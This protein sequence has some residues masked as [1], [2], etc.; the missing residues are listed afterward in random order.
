MILPA[1][2][3]RFNV[4]QQFKAK[5]ARGTGGFGSTGTGVIE[6]EGGQE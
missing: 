6:S 5:T 2:Y 4:V 3:P 1:F